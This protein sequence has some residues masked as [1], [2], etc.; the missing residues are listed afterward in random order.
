[1]P[2]HSEHYEQGDAPDFS[3]EC[4][5]GVK[6]TLG[7]DFPNLPYLID[8]DY[9]LTESNAIMRYIAGK[10]G[11]EEFSGKDAKEKSVI[12][13]MYGVI[14]DIKGANSP[15]MYGTGDKNAIVENS[16]R[17]EQ[18]SKFL[19]SNHFITGDNV[20]WVDFFLFE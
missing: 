15:H 11:P 2:Y 14:N 5:F 8:G 4:W 1:M 3:K 17:M 7:F 19:G 9:K 20:T 13:M 16:K 12:D 10:Y 6:H 18:V